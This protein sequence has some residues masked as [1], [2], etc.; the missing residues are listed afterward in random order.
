MMSPQYRKDS[1]Y[2]R[3]DLTNFEKDIVRKTQNNSKVEG[4]SRQQETGEL[5]AFTQ[6]NLELRKMVTY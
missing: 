4:Q 6:G 3:E 5:T 2:V 1:V